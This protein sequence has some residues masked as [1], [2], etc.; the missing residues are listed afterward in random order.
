[1][2]KINR[3]LALAGEIGQMPAAVLVDGYAAGLRGGTGRTAPWHLLSD[4]RPGVP[5]ILA[6]GLT[7]DNV[8]EAVRIVRPYAVDVAS[9]VES[10][11]GRKD[12]QKMKRFIA[13]VQEAAATLE[14][15]QT[16]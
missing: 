13:A 14:P 9:G 6:G 4:F 11:P 1:L 16:R 8:A 2:E 10:V 5:L 15:H 7:P 3:Y 12:P